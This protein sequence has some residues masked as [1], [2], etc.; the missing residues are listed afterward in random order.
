[1]DDTLEASQPVEDDQ[2]KLAFLSRFAPLL[3]GR[4]EGFAVSEDYQP[5]FPFTGEIG[6]VILE[7]PESIDL[8]SAH[9]H[10]A[11]NALRHD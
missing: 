8:R 7:V 11:K 10:L 1:V 3:I 2:T 9:E 4:D 5:P 6:H